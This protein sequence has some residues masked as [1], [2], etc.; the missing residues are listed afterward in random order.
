[1]TLYFKSNGYLK[2]D[3]PMVLRVKLYNDARGI[4]PRVS[5]IERTEPYS[6]AVTDGLLIAYHN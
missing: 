6:F 1:M 2:I 5:Q 3:D 4:Y